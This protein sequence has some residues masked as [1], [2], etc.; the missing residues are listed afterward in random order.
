M[1]LAF[2]KNHKIIPIL[3]VFLCFRLS[4]FSNIV[5]DSLKTQL[6]LASED[7]VV[8]LIYL[9]LG[10]NYATINTDSAIIF[11]NK[12]IELAEEINN[13]DFSANINLNIGNFLFRQGN[14][15]NAIEY[16]FK[17]LKFRETKHNERELIVPYFNIALV[18][19]K[20][21]E[22]ESAQEYY[23]KAA[24]IV[25]RL[26]KVNPKFGVQ[27][28][29]G[30]IYN[31]LGITY[32]ELND[33]D[34]ALEYYH[35][36]LSISDALGNSVALPYVYNN[37]G[38]VYQKKHDYEIALTFFQKSLDIRLKN[39]DIPGI[40]ITYYYFGDCY[41]YLNNPQKAIEYFLKGFKIAKE[42]KLTDLQKNIAELLIPQYAAINNYKESYNMHLVY[43]ELSDSLDLA[44]STKSAILLEQQYKFDKIQRDNELKQQQIIYRNILI[45]GIL[46]TL[47]VIFSLL[48]FLAQSK[49]KRI[50]LQRG[51]LRLEK[52]KLEDE[53]EY[54]NKELTTNVMYLLRKNELINSI[55]L[56]L[57]DLKKELNKSNQE[58][59]QSIINELQRSLDDDVW[60]EFEYRFKD[61]HE[62]FYK[63]LHE[64]YPELTQNERKLCAFLRLNMSTKEISAITFQSPHS[65]TIAR[66]RLRKKL[67]LTNKDINLVDFL[68]TIE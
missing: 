7:T 23:F 38:L 40:A 28:F 52:D 44:E 56:K 9:E 29:I 58:P 13:P 41:G 55:S 46:I 67:N 53:L 35:K 66:S 26:I 62:D 36:S 61:V 21:R 42:N 8:A 32:H 20:L 47:L 64:N 48:Y 24:E 34:M 4:V 33:L 6:I 54:K 19:D 60:K 57:L 37:I 11:I 25:E 12:A 51:N 16:Y 49:V 27:Y 17:I 50:K 10:N 2:K 1:I 63:A 30:R 39:N 45:G 43:K 59:I 68:S 65:I 22:F 31:N 14:Y 3:I 18:Y 15:G 5:T